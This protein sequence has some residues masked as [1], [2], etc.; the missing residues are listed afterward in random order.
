MFRGLLKKGHADDD[1]GAADT[2]A[3]LGP[4]EFTFI[5]SDTHTQEIIHPPT[6]PVSPVDGDNHLTAP[7]GHSP[8]RAR[9]SLDMFRSRSRSTSVSSRTSNNTSEKGEK[10][11]LSQ[12]LRLSRTPSASENVPQNLPEIEMGDGPG[13]NDEDDAQW[14]K[15]ATML[16]RENEKH[17][18]RP[19]TPVRDVGGFRLQENDQ[20]TAGNGVVSS[21]AIDAD[22][23]EAIRLH[24]EGQLEESTRLFG[25]LADPNG[26]NNPLSQVLY[27]LALRYVRSS[28]LGSR[29]MRVLVLGA[30][31]V[32]A[33][34]SPPPSP[35]MHLVCR[36]RRSITV[37]E[38]C[39]DEETA[40]QLQHCPMVLTP[41]LALDTGGVA[42]P[43]PRAPSTTSRRPR[44]TPPRSKAWRCRPGSRRVAPPRANSSWPSSNWPIA[45]ATG[46]G[47]PKTQLPPNRWVAPPKG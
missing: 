22:I 28:P 2:G 5:R 17:R 34:P 33:S 41:H 39:L 9:R 36:P 20:T 47:F 38:Q 32:S 3:R 4:P 23:Q 6:G 21:R 31:V 45:S 10:R 25:L 46:G 40:T 26:A 14:E 19:T 7:D 18:S 29:R 27:G 16:A 44:L 35:P 37:G 13:G 24:E 11:R 8:S 12:R 15:R 1:D 43:I 30:V 42:S